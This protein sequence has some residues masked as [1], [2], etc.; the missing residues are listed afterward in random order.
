MPTYDYECKKCKYKFQLFQ[1]I[2][3]RP[4]ARCPKCKSMAQRLISGGGG[5]IFKGSGFYVTDY[6][7]KESKS[8]KTKETKTPEKP[9]SDKKPEKKESTSE[10]KK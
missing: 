1:S 6:K 8:D 2:T 7:K 9:S 3:A 5:I 10:S 4:K